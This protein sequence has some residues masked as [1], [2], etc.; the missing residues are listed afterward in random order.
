L[1]GFSYEP[2]TRPSTSRVTTGMLRP[3]RYE[4][5][6][7]E[8]QARPR[9]TTP[10]SACVSPHRLVMIFGLFDVTV[11]EKYVLTARGRRAGLTMSKTC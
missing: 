4:M 11:R 8:R 1:C 3:R 10:R 6:T 2:A 9:S 7:D 5:V